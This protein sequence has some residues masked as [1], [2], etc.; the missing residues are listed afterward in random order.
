MNV[1]PVL[2][3]P[4]LVNA[5]AVASGLFQYCLKTLSPLTCKSPEMGPRD[6]EKT[7]LF[8]DVPWTKTAVSLSLCDFELVI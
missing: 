4:S 3:H 2:N 5:A 6:F 1:L 8:F 7:L